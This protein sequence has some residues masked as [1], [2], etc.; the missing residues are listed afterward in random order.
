L[1]A[2]PLYAGVPD[3][4]QEFASR[5]VAL[6]GPGTTTLTAI[7]VSSANAE[8]FSNFRKALQQSLQ[9]AGV[10]LRPSAQASSAIRVTLS[11]NVRGLVYLAEVQQGSDTR[12]VVM[13]AGKAASATSAAT[14]MSLRRTLLALRSEP[15]LDAAE[16]HVANETKLLL[17]GSQSALLY[18]QRGAQWIEEASVPLPRGSS[19]SLDLRGHLAPAPD[20]AIDAYLPGTVCSLALAPALRAE[21]HQADDA[22]PMGTQAAFFNSSGNYFNG[23]MRPGFGKQLPPFYT[24]AAVPY[25]SYTLWIFAGVDGQVRTHD[26]QREGSLNAHDWGSDLAAVRSGC[27]SGTQLLVTGTP[28]AGAN[29]TLRAMEIVD[30]QPVQTAPELEFPGAITALWTASDGASAVAVV[31]NSRTESYEVYRVS[32][33]CR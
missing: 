18:R 5:V 10:H 14:A 25:P 23:L 19:P 16:V 12:Y 29:D 31:R 17:L 15:V 6:A 24:V 28:A 3:A 22:W 9:E 21:C 13:E 32:V 11:E 1:L 2:C 4:V 27:G 8:Q 26:G 7:N 20:A 33:G 30:R